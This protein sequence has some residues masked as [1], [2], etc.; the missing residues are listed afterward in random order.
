MSTAKMLMAKVPR[1]FYNGY[2]NRDIVI[3]NEV[4]HVTHLDIPD[5]KCTINVV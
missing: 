2:G 5:S 1:T 3:I 4:S